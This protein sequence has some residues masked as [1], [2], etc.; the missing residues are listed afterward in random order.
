[1]SGYACFLGPIAGILVSDYWIVK[2]RRYD[3]P[4]LYDPRGI[5]R[6]SV[7]NPLRG[8]QCPLTRCQ[9]GTNWRAAVTS[10]VVVVPLLPG[11]IQKIAPDTVNVGSGLV[12]LFSFN[13]LYGFCLSIAMYVGLHT[14]FPDRPTT[15]PA[16][17]HGTPVV[18]D[19]LDLDTDSERQTHPAQSKQPIEA[20]DAKEIAVV[21][22]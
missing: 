15:I 21:A 17:I 11:M 8:M 14:A 18:I 9:N 6:Y 2:K 7:S 20:K 3:V 10:F 5:Y 12:Q 4:A 19:G 16:V 1:M 13:W 22:R